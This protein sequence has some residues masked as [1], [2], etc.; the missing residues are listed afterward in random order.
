MSHDTYPFDNQKSWERHERF[1]VPFF[2][3]HFQEFASIKYTRGKGQSL[4]SSDRLV[5]AL[6]KS[7]VDVASVC[8]KTGNTILWDEKF[9][10]HIPKN[11]CFEEFTNTMVAPWIP[12][13][14]LTSKVH[15]IFYCFIRNEMLAEAYTLNNHRLQEWYWP[16]HHDYHFDRVK[17]TPNRTG[18]RLVPVAD[19]L[20]NVPAKRYIITGYGEVKRISFDDSVSQ[21]LQD[22]HIVVDPPTHL[23]QEAQA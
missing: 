8:P 2:R 20:N 15:R 12:G 21:Y 16:V 4:T 18:N 7:G 5:I 6:Q 13:W 10:N 17:D 22:G 9:D 14:M 19:V 1:G 3:A 11:F 23:D